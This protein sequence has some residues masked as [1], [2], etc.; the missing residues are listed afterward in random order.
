MMM[1]TDDDDDDDD[2]DDDG[3]SVRILV[4]WYFQKLHMAAP[5]SWIFT[6]RKLDTIRQGVATT[7]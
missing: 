6:L 4:Y 3:E 1:M 7:I 5:H 2:N